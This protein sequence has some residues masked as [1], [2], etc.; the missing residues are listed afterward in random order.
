ME[1]KPRVLSARYLVDSA[2]DCTRETDPTCDK[3]YKV[4]IIPER[5]DTV[6]LA[7]RK[8]LPY[9]VL[10]YHDAYAAVALTDDSKI[11]MVRVPRYP[12]GEYLW[13]LPGGRHDPGETP[14][15]CVRR[16]LEEETGFRAGHIESLL[17]VYNPEPSHSTEKLGLFFATRLARTG[18]VL[19]ERDGLPVLGLFRIEEALEMIGNGEIRSSWS[20]IGLLAFFVRLRF[21]EG[22]YK[23]INPKA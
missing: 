9:T 15:E 7:D 8:R 22:E 17:P 4:M 10:E 3:E 19:A 2:G 23:L 11:A 1:Y 12:I 18:R 16:E 13:E 5:V 21:P 20:I 14:E 6:E